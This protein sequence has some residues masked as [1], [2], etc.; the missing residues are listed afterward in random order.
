MSL[1]KRTVCL[2]Y[3][4][5]FPLTH[6]GAERW[7]R[8]LGER[9][10]N[11]GSTVTYLTRRQWTTE[12]PVWPGVEIVAVSGASELYDAEGT[13]RTAPALSFGGGTF[14]W[15]VRHRRQYDA[16]VVA[17]FPFFSLLAVRGA[18]IGSGTP[19][20]VD[21]HEVW[22]SKYWRSYAGRLTGTFGSLVQKL[23]IEVTRFAQ[24]FTP[25]SAR[26]LRSQG[27]RGDVA[28][29]AGLLPGDPIRNAA[30]LTQPEGPMVLYVGR[31]VKH[32]GVRLL[33]EILAAAQASLPDLKMVVVGGGPERAD[34]ESDM[35]RLGLADAVLFTGT[36]SDEELQ[37]LY[38]QASCT[39]LPSF[40]EGYG[41]V[42]AESMS[43]GT[44]VV[45]ADNPEN[46]ATALVEPGV[47]GLVVEPSVRGMAQGVVSAIV[48]GD[49]LR[50]S[51]REWSAQFSATKSIDR[52]ADEML[53][54]LT[55]FA[56]H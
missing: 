14:W 18:L 15:M 55:T 29:L 51:T 9:L 39:I 21:Y 16:V 22:S 23:C 19:V 12:N 33:P 31:H 5:L 2:V 54:R 35:H 36:V 8:V 37:Q 1:E 26:R 43:A 11:A 48:A 24:V 38:E 42:V 27:F 17:N 49:S 56:R 3:D 47:N 40:R 34:V 10:V 20:F 4:C 44:P 41:I 52:S 45:V 28:V 53:A 32:K 25:E 13:R 30:T 50:H 6:G 46:L 7:Y